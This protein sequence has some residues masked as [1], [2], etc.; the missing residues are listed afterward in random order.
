MQ[1]VIFGIEKKYNEVLNY[2][3]SKRAFILIKFST[4]FLLKVLFSSKETF[5]IE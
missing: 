2:F 3:L 1:G 5:F 4:F